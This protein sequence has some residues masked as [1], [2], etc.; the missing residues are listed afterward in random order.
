M[1]SP[2]GGNHNAARMTCD[3]TVYTGPIRNEN[4]VHSLE[5]DAV[6]VTCND[7]ASA[8]DIRKRADTASGSWMQSVISIAQRTAPGLWG[9]GAGLL[10][11]FREQPATDRSDSTPGRLS[12]RCRVT[13]EAESGLA[14][15]SLL[16]WGT[17]HGERLDPVAADAVVHL[18]A[19]SGAKV[20]DGLPEATP[21]LVRAVLLEALPQFLSVTPGEEGAALAVLRVLADRTRADGRLNTK[22]HARLREAIDK[23]A[24]PLRAGFQLG[25][26]ATASPPSR[27]RRSRWRFLGVFATPDGLCG[28]QIQAHISQ[29]SRAVGTLDQV[30]SALCSASLN[31][32]GFDGRPPQVFERK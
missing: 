32:P 5:H 24:A 31:S 27:L 19:L 9:M 23:C 7:T 17:D 3:G 11:T 15:C 29:R 6:W 20:R 18:P 16:S 26:A 22:R 28:C 14:V 25:G 1:T 4:A 12:V 10:M 21:D 30:T 8:T 13:H 2:L